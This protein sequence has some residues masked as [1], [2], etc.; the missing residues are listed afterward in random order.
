MIG[1]WVNRI[2]FIGLS[3]LLVSTVVKYFLPGVFKVLSIIAKFIFGILKDIV[4]FT[5][6]QITSVAKKPFLPKVRIAGTRQLSK[7]FDRTFVDDRG[8]RQT[9]KETVSKNVPIFTTDKE[10]KTESEIDALQESRSF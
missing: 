9:Y 4:F 1:E 2:I 6:R 10:T 7:T 8:R 5:G 3:V